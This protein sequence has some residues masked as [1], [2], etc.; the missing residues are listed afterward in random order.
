M[1][2]WRKV[3]ELAGTLRSV[4]VLEVMCHLPLPQCKSC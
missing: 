4:K 1:S 3:V 2:V